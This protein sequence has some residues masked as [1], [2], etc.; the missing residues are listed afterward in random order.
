MRLRLTAA[1]ASALVVVAACSSSPSSPTVDADPTS[2]ATPL[3]LPVEAID[4]ALSRDPGGTRAR[5]IEEGVDPWQPRPDGAQ[6]VERQPLP[7]ESEPVAAVLCVETWP[8]DGGPV[9]FSQRLIAG[10]LQAL[11]D[12]LRRDDD[13]EQP[14]GCDG[15]YDAQPNLWMIAPDGTALAPRW[16]LDGCGH[17]REPSP[18]EVIPD[19]SLSEPALA[20]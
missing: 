19:A 6:F 1:V 7:E 20:P 4:C 17:L 15:Y 16:P 5:E 12:A 13:T 11:V 2:A 8:A 14:E 9:A 10:D 18:E 3:V